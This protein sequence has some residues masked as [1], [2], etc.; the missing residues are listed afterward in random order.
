[1]QVS[2]GVQDAVWNPVW[3]RLWK[4]SPNPDTTSPH[5]IWEPQRVWGFWSEWATHH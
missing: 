4:T 5:C 3:I 1:M 2:E